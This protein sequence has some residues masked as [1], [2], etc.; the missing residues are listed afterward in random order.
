MKR[1]VSPSKATVAILGPTNCGNE[2]LAQ[3]RLAFIDAPDWQTISHQGYHYITRRIVP[4]VRGSPVAWQVTSRALPHGR[5]PP[6][7]AAHAAPTFTVR[8]CC[9][10]RIL[11]HCGVRIAERAGG[12]QRDA[13]R[14]HCHRVTT[15]GR[16]PHGSS[17]TS[18]L[19]T[20]GSVASSSSLA[21]EAAQTRERAH[22]DAH[23]SMTR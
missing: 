14:R 2:Q 17:P 21:P 10:G 18:Q 23:K 5:S 1:F 15:V 6:R 4:H 22:T 9:H 11:P 7:P 3:P 13:C 12:G 8:T 16:E 20:C 19:M